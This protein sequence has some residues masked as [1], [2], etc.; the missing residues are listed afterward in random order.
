MGAARDACALALRNLA[1]SADGRAALLAKPHALPA[2]LR[3]LDPADLRLAARAAAALWA[4]LAKCERAKGA[5]RLPAHLG[6]LRAA[7]AALATRAMV[8]TPLIT[9]EQAL[10]AECLHAMG[11]L[12][13]ILG[14]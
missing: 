3:A 9:G 12:M 13:T 4:L 11:A 1:F 7:E 2:L 14:M 10:L 8:A 5:M 6:Q